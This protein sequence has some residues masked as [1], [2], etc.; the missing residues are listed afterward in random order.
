MPD[1]TLLLF[2]VGGTD[3]KAAVSSGGELG[4]VLRRPV[5]AGDE[6]GREL[7]EQLVRLADELIPGRASADAS[8]GPSASN[9]G[10]PIAAAGL[11]SPGLVDVAARR[12]IFAANLGLRAARL[13]DLLEERLGV[14]VGFGHDV[15][16]A[17]EAEMAQGAGAGGADSVLV[18]VIGTGI[19]ATPFVGGRRVEVPGA[20]ELG[21]V[22]VPGGRPCACGAVGCLETVASAAA[23]ARAYMEATGHRVDGAVDVVR[24]MHAGDPAAQQAAEQVW[25]AAVEALAFALHGVIGLLGTQ[26]VIVGGGLSGAGEALLTPLRAA[27]AARLSFMPVPEIV[28]ARLGGDA[29]LG[30][31]R[32][33]ALRE[34][35]A[36]A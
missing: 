20:G 29:G 1:P 5:V 4:P 25:S 6:A 35:E 13:P 33:V 21:H 9:A 22:P 11:L 12:T 19:A 36:R 15:G 18:M 32:L 14:P 16:L 31:A 23:I 27:L 30:G 28:P 34:L 7:V 17:A 24:A 26:R 3:V 10:T 8:A 2:D